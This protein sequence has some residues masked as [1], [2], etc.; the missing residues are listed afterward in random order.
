VGNRGS[1]KDNLEG[2]IHNSMDLIEK[3]QD[4]INF[5]QNHL[6]IE[7]NK[8]EIARQRGLI[9]GFVDEYILIW[10]RLQF[11]IPEDI[12]QT[13]YGFPEY[14]AL[15]LGT[16]TPKAVA[17][18]QSTKTTTPVT[19]SG[20]SQIEGTVVVP[21]SPMVNLGKVKLAATDY[22]QLRGFLLADNRFT[23]NPR[24]FLIQAGIPS[25]EVFGWALDL[26]IPMTLAEDV[27][28][29][30]SEYGSLEDLPYHALGA[31][32]NRLREQG[33]VERKKYLDGL[34]LQY[35]LIRVPQ[36]VSDA[37][38]VKAEQES[39]TP[40]ESF[41][42]T[43]SSEYKNHLE[44]MHE[45]EKWFQEASFL[46]KGAQRLKAIC[47]VETREKPLGTGFL[48]APDLVL[49]NY[50]VL[51]DSP[52]DSLEEKA[53]NLNF[54]FGYMKDGNQIIAGV[55]VKAVA[56]GAAVVKYS[57]VKKLDYALIR[58][59]EEVG[60]EDK[61]GFLK[62][63]PRDIVPWETALVMQHPQGQP[64]KFLSNLV[65]GHS[66]D[67]TR[68]HYLTGTLPGSS[69]SPVFDEEW[70]VIALHHSG[71]PLPAL[72]AELDVEA[73]EGI[74][75]KAIMEEIGEYL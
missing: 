55:V 49:T 2:L 58:L 1:R 64:M 16:P 66:P 41:D 20:N 15:N 37:G 29:K 28:E 32:I 62:I 26:N 50:H 57:L 68:V 22:K 48:V 74:T 73:N 31:V 60:S 10:N 38:T 24:N 46:T 9:K 44:S 70:Q 23:S 12:K 47:R 42:F 53:H 69:G 4:D 6:E 45:P 67:N 71:K 54:R 33:G 43:L 7:R 13:I 65:V 3:L 25:D 18:A 72:S 34:L 39:H 27:L 36:L 52:G 14:A 17:P 30:I 63:T 59:E 21:S 61:F 51:R 5:S 8:R 75:M 19:V 11:E 56:T 40:E 35:K